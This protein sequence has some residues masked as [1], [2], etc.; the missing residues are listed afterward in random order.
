MAARRS[1][2]GRAPTLKDARRENHWLWLHCPNC[3]HRRAVMLARYLIL[4]GPDEQV[5]TLRRVSTCS[6]CGHRG[7]LTF[8]PSWGGAQIGF[9]PFPGDESLGQQEVE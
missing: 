2:R 8:M 9:L 4:W 3:P 1:E 5:T 7:A 6:A